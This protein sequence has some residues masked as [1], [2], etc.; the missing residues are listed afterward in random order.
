[1][2]GF[3]LQM[4]DY[5]HRGTAPA[6]RFIGGCAGQWDI[7]NLTCVWVSLEGCYWIRKGVMLLG[8]G[9]T[10][11]VGGGCAGVASKAAEGRVSRDTGRGTHIERHTYC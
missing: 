4:L 1:M 2:I 8:G 9:L 3:A 7:G 11:G 6:V 5:L 10:N